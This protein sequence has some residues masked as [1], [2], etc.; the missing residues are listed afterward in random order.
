MQLIIKPGR[1]VIQILLMVVLVVIFLKLKFHI[2]V[3]THMIFKL[4]IGE[5]VGFCIKYGNPNDNYGYFPNMVL[6]E[7]SPANF[8]TS[9]LN[10]NGKTRFSN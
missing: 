9:I 6:N 2:I 4:K 3:L 1:F 10:V 7:E 5:T 8:L